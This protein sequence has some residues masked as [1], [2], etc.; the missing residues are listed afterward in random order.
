MGTNLLHLERNLEAKLLE[1]QEEEN[2][3]IQT[4]GNWNPL[5]SVQLSYRV[6]YLLQKQV[7]T[8]ML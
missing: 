2:S 5:L 6:K 1:M 3:A 8:D 7:L 4:M